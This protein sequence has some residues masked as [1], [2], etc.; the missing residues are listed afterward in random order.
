M[1]LKEAR[2]SFLKERRATRRPSPHTLSAYD[3]DLLA[4]ER[5]LGSDFAVQRL[6]EAQIVSFLTFMIDGGLK[7]ATVRRRA[8]VVRLFSRWLASSGRLLRDPW[9][10]LPLADG[11][12]P[13]PG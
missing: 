7:A 11:L 10:D 12:A 1:N 8:I 4:L 9:G 3:S 5:F 2:Q 6:D 13:D